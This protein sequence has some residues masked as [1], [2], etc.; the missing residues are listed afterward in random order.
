MTEID[1]SKCRSKWTLDENDI[2]KSS[3]LPFKQCKKCREQCKKYREDNRD[4]I[5]E[6]KKKWYENNKNKVLEQK[7]E[8]YE[9]NKHKVLERVKKYRELNK[10]KIAEKIKCNNCGSEITKNHIS[11]HQKTKK[12]QKYNK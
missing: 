8:Y 4:K 3:A 12:C 11:T 10:D 2:C 1:C 7:K 9:N 5:A 6:Q